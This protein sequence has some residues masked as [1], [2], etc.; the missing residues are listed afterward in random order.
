MDKAV[1]PVAPRS[2]LSIPGSGWLLW[3]LD[4][5][6][7]AF[8]RG[9]DV[10]RRLI[11]SLPEMK[12]ATGGARIRWGVWLDQYVLPFG[13]DGAPI[14]S[15]KTAAAIFSFEPDDLFLSSQATYEANRRWENFV[16]I[17]RQLADERESDGYRRIGSKRPSALDHAQHPRSSPLVG[18]ARELTFLDRAYARSR[19]RH[20]RVAVVGEAGSGKTRLIGEW[21]TRDSGRRALWAGFSLFGGDVSSL[22]AQLTGAASCDEHRDVL[23]SVED[24]IAD[25]GFSVVVLDDLHWADR[26]GQAFT[27]ELLSRLSSRPVL[28]ILAARPRAAEMLWALQPDETLSVQRLSPVDAGELARHLIRSVRLAGFAVRASRGNPLFIEQ[29]AAWSA[30]VGRTGLRDMPRT[31][32]DVI[33]ARIAHLRDVRL[34]AIR[35]R[36]QAGSPWERN[37]IVAELDEIESEIGLWLDRLETGDYGDRIDAARHVFALERIDF[38]L[39]MLRT[40]SGLARPRS[41]RLREAIER[42]VLGSVREILLELRHRL[43]AGKAGARGTVGAEAERAADIALHACQWEN[44]EELLQIALVSAPDWQRESL[45]E[46]VG[47]CQERLDV[48]PEDRPLVPIDVEASPNVDALTLP[49]V[50]MKLGYCDRAAD[51]AEAINDRRFAEWARAQSRRPHFG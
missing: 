4:G 40:L 11:A 8:L 20:A 16:C 32:Y 28:A 10:E 31:L 9:V 1:A 21:L 29:F 38:D 48:S 34:A 5:L 18:R 24:R 50:W 33:A 41:S 46:R 6:R 36:V 12:E 51:A 49:Q 44:A 3:S 42:L 27:H 25:G 47:A 22:V 45:R 35:R 26:D 43:R 30:E 39:F 13:V 23:N 2:C 14:I 17:P 37:L 7:A 19:M 15:P